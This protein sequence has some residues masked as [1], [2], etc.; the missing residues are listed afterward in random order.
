MQSYKFD[1]LLLY[2]VGNDV[3]VEF[4][5]SVGA[6]TEVRTLV[7]MYSILGHMVRYVC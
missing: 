3:V 5:L 4:L 6:S 2:N 1:L 7:T